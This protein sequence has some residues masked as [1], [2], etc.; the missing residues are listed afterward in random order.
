MRVEL[1]GIHSATCRSLS[2]RLIDH[3]DFSEFMG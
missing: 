3:A 2:L 1:I